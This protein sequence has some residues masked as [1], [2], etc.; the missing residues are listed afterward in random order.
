[1]P[2]QRL[3]RTRE[4][5]PICYQFGDARPVLCYFCRRDISKEAKVRMPGDRP[6]TRQVE[7]TDCAKLANP[8]S[9][10]AD[11][12]QRAGY[13]SAAYRITQAQLRADVA[14]GK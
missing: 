8:L 6:R 14:R 10:V 2:E 12:L 3:Q 7:C 13:A 9:R 5:L 4:T 1:M 11:S